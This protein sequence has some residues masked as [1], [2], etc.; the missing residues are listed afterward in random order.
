GLPPRRLATVNGRTYWMP[1]GEPPPHVVLQS[2]TGRADVG[3][4]DGIVR[5]PMQGTIVTLG[6]AVGDRVE[7]DQV[8]CVLE[9]MKMENPLRAGRNGVVTA[10][11]VAVGDTV[12]PAQ[13]LLSIEADDA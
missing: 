10:L 2:A 4:S 8:V 11:D 13:V 9:A 6:C 5:S 7:A 12:A 1:G 3:S